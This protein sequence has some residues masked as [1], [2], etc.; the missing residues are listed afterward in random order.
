MRRKEEQ[1]KKGNEKGKGKQSK[2]EEQRNRQKTKREEKENEKMKPHFT[3]WES[4]PPHRHTATHPSP[5][6]NLPPHISHITAHIY[7][8]DYTHSSP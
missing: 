3:C 8:Q 6:S 1:K 2:T 4:N 7:L 5:I